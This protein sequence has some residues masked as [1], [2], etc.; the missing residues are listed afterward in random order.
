MGWVIQSEI[1]KLNHGLTHVE[2]FVLLTFASFAL[3]DGSSCYPAVGTVAKVTVLSERTV[4]R[5]VAKFIEDGVMIVRRREG[6]SRPVKYQINLTRAKD[7]YYC[8]YEGDEP[9]DRGPKKADSLSGHS[10]GKADSQSKKADSLSKSPDSLSGNPIKN[11]VEN[12]S[13]ARTRDPEA[14][15][16]CAV[17]QDHHAELCA[18]FGIDVY[19]DWLKLCIPE[20]DVDGVLTLAVPTV[21]YRDHIDKTYKE[22]LQNTLGRTVII[23]Q[24]GWS[25]D[26][27][28]ARSY[29]A[30]IAEEKAGRR[31]GSRGG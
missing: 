19:N 9:G 26:A 8:P 24:R 31:P 4:R 20:S 2:K 14:A 29:Q 5:T 1:T 25:A 30:R 7:L 18:D 11:P 6:R 3:D 17:W 22:G 21:F 13:R 12:P 27:N 28:W 23:V 16:A 15:P 10:V